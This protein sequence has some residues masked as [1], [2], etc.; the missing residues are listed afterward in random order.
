MTTDDH[1]WSF[2]DH[3]WPL[4]TTGDHWWH[5]VTSRYVQQQASLCI[6]F[7]FLPH[8]FF[9]QYF[10][11]LLAIYLLFVEFV[12]RYANAWERTLA[13]LKY[14]SEN[15]VTLKQQN[16]SLTIKN[17]TKKYWNVNLEKKTQE[18]ECWKLSIKTLKYFKSFLLNIQPSQPS[19]SSPSG[20]SHAHVRLDAQADVGDRARR[21]EQRDHRVLQR[22]WLSDVGRSA[23]SRRRQRWQKTKR[24][25]C[26]SV[27]L[28]ICVSVC[29]CVCVYV[30]LCV[31]VCLCVS[32]CL[33]VCVSVC[34]CV[35][36][37][38][39]LRVCVCVCWFLWVFACVC[40]SVCVCVWWLV[41]GG[42][43]LAVGGR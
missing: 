31:C 9:T 24:F 23:K 15:S 10:L 11:L 37:S 36:V 42:W 18:H 35:C 4:V 32:V 17:L 5:Q 40:V 2:G 19:S 34:L 28:C 1:W 20:T 30:S 38:V 14:H 27:Y 12:T 25:V 13:E 8:L 26:V 33:C 41:V 3:W 43:R 29:L 21:Q 7:S 16:V 39:C 6:Y 22:C